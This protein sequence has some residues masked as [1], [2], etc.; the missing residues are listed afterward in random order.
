M[1]ED[2]RKT[3]QIIALVDEATKEQI[4]SVAASAGVSRGAVVRAALAYGLR[5][6]V[7]DAKKG[8]LS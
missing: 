5:F 8:R 1:A 6:A 4:S 7:R 3:A 2:T